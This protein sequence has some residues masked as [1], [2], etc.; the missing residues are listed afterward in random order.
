MGY[1]SC[2]SSSMR[3]ALSPLKRMCSF[4]CLRCLRFIVAYRSN[5]LWPFNL[6][7]KCE[8]V[9]RE[10]QLREFRPRS[11]F[12][13]SKSRLPRLIVVV[14]SKPKKDWPEDLVRMLLSGA[15]IIRFANKFLDRFKAAKNFVLFAIYIW[16]DGKV[17]RYSLFQKP[18]DPRVCRTLYTTKL[19]G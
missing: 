1:F 17:S 11:D 14:N 13:V 12:F 3:A 18:N 9:R 10:E 4:A 19:A 8:T 2:I 6:I 15:T 7:T 5:E 16:E